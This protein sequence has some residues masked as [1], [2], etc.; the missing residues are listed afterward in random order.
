[1]HGRCAARVGCLLLLLL[2]VVVGESKVP[3]GGTRPKG[4]NVTVVQG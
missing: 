1:M 2:V 4:V 3:G